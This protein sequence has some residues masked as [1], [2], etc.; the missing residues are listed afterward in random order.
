MSLRSLLLLLIGVAILAFVGVNWVAITTPTQLSLLFTEIEAPLGLVML[1][2]L[3]GVACVFVIMIAYIQ[4]TVLVE[5]RRHARELSAQR[6]LADKA[7][8]SRFTDLRAH[9]DQ[10]MR[11]L[12]ESLTQITQETVARVDRAEMGLREHSGHSEISRL[13]QTLDD[14]NRDLH[15]RIDRLEMGLGDRIAHPRQAALP[16]APVTP[17]ASVALV[18]HPAVTPPA[19][20]LKRAGGWKAREY[21]DPCY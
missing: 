11:R 21:C 3:V 4:G 12:G 18:T 8:A 20:A 19:G 1:G 5:T 9:L 16:A 10:E 7:E 2:M 6:E 15:A 14:F 13:A 17:A